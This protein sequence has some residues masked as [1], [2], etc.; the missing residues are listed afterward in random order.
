M[1]PSDPTK[2][3]IHND[4]FKSLDGVTWT[5]VTSKFLFTPQYKFDIVKFNNVY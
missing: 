3:L 2:L 1:D 4:M 5:L